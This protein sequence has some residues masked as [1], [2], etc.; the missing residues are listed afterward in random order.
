MSALLEKILMFAL[1][2]RPIQTGHNRCSGKHIV[3]FCNGVL[4]Q[5]AA[6]NRNKNTFNANYVAVQQLQITQILE[7]QLIRKLQRP[8]RSLPAH[9][10]QPTWPNAQSRRTYRIDLARWPRL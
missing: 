10:W 9:N 7:I 1:K 8:D 5:G 4:P 3:R 6:S 2:N